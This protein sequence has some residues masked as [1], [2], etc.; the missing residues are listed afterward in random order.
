[1][2]RGRI[3]PDRQLECP[4]LSPESPEGDVEL[5]VLYEREQMSEEITPLSPLFWPVLDSGRYLGETLRR[6][7]LYDVDGR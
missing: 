5:M 2:L 1:M 7:E 3:H 4:S 6:D